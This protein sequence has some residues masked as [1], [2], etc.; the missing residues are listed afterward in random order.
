MIG[1]TQLALLKLTGREKAVSYEEFL[2]RERQQD[3]TRV[4]LNMLA[5]AGLVSI[6]NGFISMNV[7]QRIALAERLIHSGLDPVR[8]SRDLEWQ[9]FENFAND[10]L[11]DNGFQCV[12]HFIFK[13]SL[14][15]REIDIVAWNDNF[16]LAIDCKHWRRGMFGRRM[17]LAAKA[18]TERI[19]ALAKRPELLARAK[20]RKVQERT[21]IPLILTM[22]DAPNGTIEGVPIVPISKLVSF[23]Y[24]LSP[25]DPEILQ[26]HI[27]NCDGQSL[28]L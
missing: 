18:Q 26:I 13:S 1:E 15:R 6:A 7:T 11:L 20:M 16:L 23:L 19:T 27:R 28:L 9:E 4:T 25:M 24:G 8:V 17:A 10:V 12:K 2:A 5:D 22:G 14:G 21:I 3:N